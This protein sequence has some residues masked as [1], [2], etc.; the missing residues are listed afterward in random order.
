[1]ARRKIGRY[2]EWVTR[3]GADWPIHKPEDWR[4]PDLESDPNHK[5][6]GRRTCRCGGVEEGQKE[7]ARHATARYEGC[8]GDRASRTAGR[9]NAS[10]HHEGNRLAG[11]QRT[12][13]RERT[14]RQEAGPTNP[15]VQARRRT[16]L[17]NES[18][19]ASRL[20]RS[21]R[22]PGPLTRIETKTDVS[23]DRWT[24][25]FAMD[26]THRKLTGDVIAHG[27]AH[28]ITHRIRLVQLGQW[29]PM[30]IRFPRH[31][32]QVLDDLFTLRVD[33][34]APLADI[35]AQH[36]V[37]AIHAVLNAWIAARHAESRTVTIPITAEKVL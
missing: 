21:L 32:F 8:P 4:Q 13:L 17:Q 1:M 24:R 27:I 16:R 19:K 3:R 26:A 34:Q 18:I 11:A 29:V 28:M 14:A 25:L 10:G 9:R 15:L 22:R 37:D 36:S 23:D 20:A 12:R 31:L 5:T 7:G 6:S 35:I 33:Q 2:L 30:R